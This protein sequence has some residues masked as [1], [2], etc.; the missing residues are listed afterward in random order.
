MSDPAADKRHHDHEAT[1]GGLETRL[2]IAETTLAR[3]ETWRTGDE[4]PHRGAEARITKIEEGAVMTTDMKQIAQE[5]V[6]AYLR[7]FRG[8]LA[9]ALPWVVFIAGIVLYLTT[10]RAPPAV[11]P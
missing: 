6:S 3:S 1:M 5:V 7:S 10:G 9:T 2:G 11:G 4:A 8:I